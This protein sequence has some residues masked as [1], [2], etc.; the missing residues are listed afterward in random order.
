[1]GEIADQ[2]VEEEMFGYAHEGEFKRAVHKRKF[3]PT[4]R[5]ILSIKKEIAILINQEGV[6]ICKA[7]QMMNIKYGKGWR[8]G[9]FN[10]NL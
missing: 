1:M 4:Q 6:E 3:N 5:K 8:D 9:F 7:R 10:E 2:L